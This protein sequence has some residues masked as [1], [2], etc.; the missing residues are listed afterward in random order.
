MIELNA[1]N[2]NISKAN[3]I[4]FLKEEVGIAQNTIKFLEK[5]REDVFKLADDDIPI[6]GFT[7]GV[8]L[9]KDRKV[10]AK[11][12][13]KYNKNLIY[14]HSLGYGKH[15][16]EK[17]AR[18]IV[19]ASLNSLL[20]GTMACSLEIVIF[21]KDCLNKGISP[22]IPQTGS[23][24][25]GDISLMSHIGLL[26]L[27]EGKCFFNKK[28]IKAK[29]ALKKADIKKISFGPKDGLAVVSSSAV[30]MGDM[31]ISLEKLEK[32]LQLNDLIYSLSLEGVNGNTGPLSRELYRLRP[33]KG[34]R[35]HL[36]N[37]LFYLKDSRLF[38]ELDDR[39][40][41]DPLCFRNYTWIVG[42]LDDLA[43]TASNKLLIALN[44]SG[45]NPCFHKGKI[46]SSSNYEPIS[47]ILDWETLNIALDHLSKVSVYRSLKLSDSNFSGLNRFLAPSQNI[48]CFQTIGKRLSSLQSNIRFL[49]N[50][51]SL[52]YF[53]LA[54]DIEDHAT[55]SPFVVQ[56][57]RKSL[58]YFYEI[59]SLEALHAVQAIRL[60]KKKDNIVL[61]P[62]L[63]KVLKHIDNFVDFYDKERPMHKECIKMKK[64]LSSLDISKL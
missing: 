35:K 21:L 41:Q 9:N 45:D 26:M 54:G 59:L 53:S 11:D 36:K 22:I 23:V 8:G 12:Y 29:E 43:A 58:K 37:I 51:G 48:A 50:P 34:A 14:A 28:I 57:F 61:S 42:A 49:S 16:D 5:Q 30:T 44:S 31:L 13:K 27:G 33:F 18:A 15:Y 7:R 46:Y 32:I 25:M 24:G 1:K 38:G 52:D 62:V 56:K 10:L 55:N 60:R 6:Y 2:L 64:A 47:F 20:Q 3:R 4:I 63:E 39:A 19:L 17:T 40:L